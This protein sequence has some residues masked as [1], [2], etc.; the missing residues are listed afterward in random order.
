MPG[1]AVG[2]IQEYKLV[3]ILGGVQF[4]HS[5]VSAPERQIP[6]IKMDSHLFLLLQR[7]LHYIYSTCHGVQL[8]DIVD[9]FQLIDLV[10]FHNLYLE[11]NLLYL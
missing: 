7:P 5:T 9:V 6:C 1:I 10:A 4:K 2:F 8:E 3:H 11:L